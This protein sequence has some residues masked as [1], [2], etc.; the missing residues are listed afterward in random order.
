V[1][2]FRFASPALPP[3][4]LEEEKEVR[5]EGVGGDGDPPLLMDLRNGATQRVEWADAFVEEEAKDVPLQRG[6]LFADD[7][8]NMKAVGD[9]HL[10]CRLRR[11]N[12][13]VIGD[14]DDVEADLF[15]VREY[16]RN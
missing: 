13:I 8:L 16:L 3:P 11:I 15:R 5:E 9:R 6:D 1:D 7:H 12:A 4:P 10:L 2:A 14:G